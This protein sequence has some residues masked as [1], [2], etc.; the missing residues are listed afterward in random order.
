MKYHR[1]QGIGLLEAVVGAAII[2]TALVGILSSFNISIRGGLAN[3]QKIQ[4]AL[5]AEEGLE[6]V[7]YLRDS[8]WTANIAPLASGTSYYLHWDNGWTL[9]TIFVANNEFTRTITFDEAYRDN[10]SKK[11]VDSNPSASVDV[12]TIQVTA[13]VIWENGTT[14]VA[15]YL[16][17]LLNN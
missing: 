2:A 17:N 15:T 1:K 14:T 6:A 11:I 3:T 5:L 9:S 12:N 16:T 13:E 10:A 4:A 7:R 8:S